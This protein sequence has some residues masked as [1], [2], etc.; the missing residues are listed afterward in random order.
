MQL[1][2]EPIK[3]K[4]ERRRTGRAAIAAAMRTQ[5]ERAGVWPL[6]RKR[7]AAATYTSPATR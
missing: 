2:V 1:Y 5:F 4:Q 6:M 7:I 3:V